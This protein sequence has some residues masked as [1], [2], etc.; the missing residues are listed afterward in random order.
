MK[1]FEFYEMLDQDDFD[2][3]VEKGELPNAETIYIA[4]RLDVIDSIFNNRLYPY[5][6]G[7]CKGYYV[8]YQEWTFG[9]CC[10]GPRCWM[11]VDG[12]SGLTLPAGCMFYDVSAAEL[13]IFQLNV[14]KELNAIMEQYKSTPGYDYLAQKIT[15]AKG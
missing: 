5:T 7:S 15:E 2:E 6:I 9:Y 10:L 8:E 3:K 14:T 13:F 4:F 11:I 12:K 1:P